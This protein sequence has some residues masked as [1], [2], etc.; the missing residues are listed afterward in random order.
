MISRPELDKRR[1][2]KQ[3]LEEQRMREN[4]DRLRKDMEKSRGETVVL[5]TGLKDRDEKGKSLMDDEE[6]EEGEDEEINFDGISDDEEDEIDEDDE[7][8]ASFSF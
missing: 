2:E 4:M 8:V 5:N 1:I 6:L 7:E 3:Q